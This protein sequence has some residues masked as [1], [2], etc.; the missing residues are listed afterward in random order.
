EAADPARPGRGIAHDALEVGSALDRRIERLVPGEI[1]DVRALA[2]IA[3]RAHETRQG[4][5]LG[6]VLQVVPVVELLLVLGPGIEPHRD[7]ALRLFHGV[8]PLME[9]GTRA[10]RPR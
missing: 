8:L 4:R 3:A 7:Q 9:A 5:E 2:A 6:H 1:A 10:A